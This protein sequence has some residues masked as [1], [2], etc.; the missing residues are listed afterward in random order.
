[1]NKQSV[2]TKSALGIYLFIYFAEVSLFLNV[3]YL[4][5]RPAL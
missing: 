1:M 5:K 4:Y 3:N 2:Y